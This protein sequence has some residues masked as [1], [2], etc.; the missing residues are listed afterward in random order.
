MYAEGLTASD[1]IQGTPIKASMV[2]EYLK[3]AADFV[4]IV[5]R[6]AE[7]PVTGPRSGKQFSKN[8]QLAK[9]YRRWEAIPNRQQP[10]TKKMIQDEINRTN[11]WYQDCMCVIGLHMGRPCGRRR[12]EID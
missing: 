1:T 6:R 3:A 2:S 5:G 7:C 8:T 12:V 11:G 4:K 10:L 9:K